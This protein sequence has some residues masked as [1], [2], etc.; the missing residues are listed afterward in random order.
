MWFM[1]ETSSN[2]PNA[3]IAPHAGALETSDT[4]VEVKP[5]TMIE[6]ASDIRAAHSALSTPWR[7]ALALLGV[8]CFVLAVIGAVVPGMP[9]T[10]F[11]LVGSFFLTRSCPWLEDKMFAIPLLRPYAKFIRST[12]PMSLK[13]RRTAWFS[14][15]ISILVSMTLLAIAGKLTFLLAGIIIGAGLFG[16]IAIWRFRRPA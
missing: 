12:E 7:W 15:W 6:S 13:M 4:L 9:I 10:V 14:M 8:L 2:L 5:V 16:T 11:L 1:S 3:T